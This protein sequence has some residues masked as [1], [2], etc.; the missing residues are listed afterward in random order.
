MEEGAR[1]KFRGSA[2][3][4]ERRLLSTAA[5]RQVR[6]KGATFARALTE[7]ERCATG[8]GSAEVWPRNSG[9][10][11][12]KVGFDELGLYFFIGGLPCLFSFL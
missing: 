11:G 1:G 12:P 8:L 7:W 3:D 6:G 9:L 10:R 2:S 5:S 4:R